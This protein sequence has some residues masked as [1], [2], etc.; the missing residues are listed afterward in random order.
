MIFQSVLHNLCI[1][2]VYS[3]CVGLL[4]RTQFT[5]EETRGK[6]KHFFYSRLQLYNNIGGVVCLARYP[7]DIVI[8]MQPLLYVPNKNTLLSGVR[9]L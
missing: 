3:V 1:F 6:I 5:G 9:A 4:C 7:L 2:Y 8:K